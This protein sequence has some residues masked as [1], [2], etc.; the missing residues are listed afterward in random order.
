MVPYDLLFMCLFWCMTLLSSP[1]Y[2]W[3]A[4]I[5]KRINFRIRLFNLDIPDDDPDV[6]KYKIV[7]SIANLFY[8]IGLIGVAGSF[9]LLLMHLLR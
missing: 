6:K 2:T 9:A 3:A 7:R 4:S 8:R 1:F 5:E